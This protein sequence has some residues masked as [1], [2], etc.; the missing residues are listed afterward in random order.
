MYTCMYVYIYIHISHRLT[1]NPHTTREKKHH[2]L[3]SS[4][5]LKPVPCLVAREPV[6]LASRVAGQ[7]LQG[8]PVL[9]PAAILM[10]KP[11]MKT[12]K[13]IA[14]PWENGVFPGF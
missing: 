3:R 10:A 13:I 6:P 5:H 14:I 9:L 2:R 8:V 12:G 11:K 7:S 4:A 1:R